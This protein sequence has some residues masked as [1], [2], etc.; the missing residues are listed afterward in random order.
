MKTV[1]GGIVALLGVGILIG[2]SFQ[3]EP[4]KAT[5]QIKIENLGCGQTFPRLYPNKTEI[6]PSQ[7]VE[8]TK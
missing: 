3:P 4:T 1:A 7:L 6:N 5:N 8:R 2:H